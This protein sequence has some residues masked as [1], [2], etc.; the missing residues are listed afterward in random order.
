VQP[1][2]GM[3]GTVE[4]KNGDV[5]V[6]VDTTDTVLL[7]FILWAIPMGFVLLYFLSKRIH[8]V[9]DWIRHRVANIRQTG[10]EKPPTNGK[11]DLEGR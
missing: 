5:T 9:F 4:V 3:P 2:L 6:K 10:E 7:I 1:I 11:R 8:Y